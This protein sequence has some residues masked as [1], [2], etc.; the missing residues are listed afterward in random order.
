MPRYLVKMQIVIQE[1][2][3]GS[4][5]FVFNK[6]PCD[7]NADGA[8]TTYLL[9]SKVLHYYVLQVGVLMIIKTW[10]EHLACSRHYLKYVTG[11]LHLKF[12]TT[13]EVDK[14]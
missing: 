13:V 10:I 2:W 4:K 3:G 9:S 12:I 1:V 14:Y 5:G 7:V 8:Q 6:H 11:L